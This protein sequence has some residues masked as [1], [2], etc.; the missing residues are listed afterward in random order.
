MTRLWTR[1]RMLVVLLASDFANF[2]LAINST[3]T[4]CSADTVSA[5][6]C[7]KHTSMSTVLKSTYNRNSFRAI[8]THIFSSLG[9]SV[10]LCTFI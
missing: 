4:H 2:K 9:A 5:L 1:L 3:F 7:S 10:K 8:C 6:G